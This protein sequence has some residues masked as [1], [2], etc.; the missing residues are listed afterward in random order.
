MRMSRPGSNIGILSMFVVGVLVVLA[1][2][3]V[4]AAVVL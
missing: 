4:I 1:I 2:M 3:W